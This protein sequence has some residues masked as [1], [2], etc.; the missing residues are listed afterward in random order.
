MP[1]Q[2]ALRPIAALGL[3]LGVGCAVGPTFVRPKTSPEAGYGDIPRNLDG[4]GSVQRLKDGA[5][6]PGDWWTLFHNPALNAWVE[7][8]LNANPDLA[9]SQAAL[10]VA[11]ENLLAQKGAYWPSVN[12]SAS[13]TRAKTSGDLSPA[14]NSGAQIYNLFTPQVAVSFVPDVFGLN[15]RTVESLRAQEQQARFA[16]AASH[17]TLST[18]V[19]AA[20]VQQASLKAQVEATQ[21]IILASEKM[22]GILR[23]QHAQGYVGRLDVAAQESQLAQIRATLP[24]L[25]KQ[26]AQQ[27][28]LLAALAGCFPG[29][30]GI[31]NVDLDSLRLPED[32]PVSLPSALIEQRPDIRQAEEALHAACAQVGIARANRLPNLTLTADAGSASTALGRLFTPGTAFWDAGLGLTQPLFQGG[33]LM[34]RERAARAA[35]DQAS[36]QYRGTVLAAFQNVA[37]ALHALQQD[38]EGL[39]AATA[40]KEAAE[41]TLELTKKQYAAGYVNYLALLNAEQT[42]QQAQLNHIQARAARLADSAA[43]FQALGGG[44]WHRRDI[45]ER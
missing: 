33:T 28:D 44:W 37:D 36:E 11:R 34:H 40:A 29:Q 9:A 6:V 5:D 4:G 41:V 42:F 16:L 30:Q 43:L 18:N 23:D 12:A 32:L 2:K 24:P 3:A 25:M 19:V 1:S 39:K 7:R 31:P 45:P 22:L 15:R 26:M 27:G 8:A 38:A 20:L 35:F 13:A 21:A 10:H 14:P 17:I